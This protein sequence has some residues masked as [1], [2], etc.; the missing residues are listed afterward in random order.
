[1]TGKILP[2]IVLMTAEEVATLLRVDART[3]N[4]RYA[5]KK[6]FPGY[7]KIGKA[8]LWRRDEVLKHINES[9]NEAVSRK[10]AA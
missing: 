2:D 8:K 6:G 1:M 10:K 4:E 9:I 5:Y 3:V 7:V